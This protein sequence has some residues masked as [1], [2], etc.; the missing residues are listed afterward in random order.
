M[1]SV[2][3]GSLRGRQVLG[4]EWA[5]GRGLLGGNACLLQVL[6]I[7]STARL[8]GERPGSERTAV[9]S[10]LNFIL[11]GLLLWDSAIFKR[12]LS[13]IW[14]ILRNIICLSSGSKLVETWNH[15][16]R[17]RPFP[18]NIFSRFFPNKTLST[19]IYFKIRTFLT[20]LVQKIKK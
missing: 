13:N 5:S 7:E 18:E 14:I 19:K 4:V 20:F 12:L 17:S 16:Q 10:S 15:F 1:N 3:D 9:R 11:K 2:C 8:C 6:V